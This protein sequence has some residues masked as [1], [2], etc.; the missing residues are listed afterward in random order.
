MALTDFFRINL[1]YGVSRN[2][3]GEWFAFNREYMPLGW[4]TQSSK[5]NI[6]DDNVYSENPVYTK[7]RG[8]TEKKLVEIAGSTDRIILDSNGKIERVFLYNDNTN[9]QS[10]PKYWDE[11]FQKI[12]I[13][14]N[15]KVEAV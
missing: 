15:L 1:P 13:L 6:A 5:K 3:K 11:Y 7:Y 2:S 10:S 4:N 8:L 9:P 12:K 14:S